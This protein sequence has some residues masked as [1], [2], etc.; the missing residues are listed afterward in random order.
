MALA[1]EYIWRDRKRHFGLP[2]SFTR[3]S[4]CE[5]R[6]FQSIGLFNVHEDETLLYRVRDIAVR[7]SLGQRIFGV[8][9]VTVYS[10]DKTQ[11]SLELKNIKRPREV[12]ELLHRQVE[13]MKIARRMR[14]GE[15]LE[16]YDEIDDGPDDDE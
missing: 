8:G 6:L 15:M 7:I 9:T 16:N 14:L 5:D 13:E 2:L 1:I 10:S 12:K 4:L 3:Y 11:P